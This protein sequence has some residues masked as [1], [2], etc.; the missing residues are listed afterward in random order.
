MNDI[1]GIELECPFR[2]DSGCD[3]APEGGAL[4]YDGFALSAR[5][6]TA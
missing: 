2:A 6:L 3:Q 1:C 5:C 4:G